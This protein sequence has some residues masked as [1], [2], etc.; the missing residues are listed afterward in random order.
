MHPSIH[1][2]S[3]IDKLGTP[4]I[5]A[6]IPLVPKP[7]TAAAAYSPTR[8]RPRSAGRP[9]PR[10]N[11]FALDSALTPERAKGLI[12]AGCVKNGRVN[13]VDEQKSVSLLQAPLAAGQK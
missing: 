12:L 9:A 8:P 10:R 4:F 13:L 6:F 11:P 1:Q 2:P 3:R 7:H 5:A